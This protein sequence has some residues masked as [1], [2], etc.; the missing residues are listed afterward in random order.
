MY[1]CLVGSD[2][3]EEKKTRFFSRIPPSP[4]PHLRPL[5]AWIP[6]LGCV[7]EMK[8]NLHLRKKHIISPSSGSTLQKFCIK[9]KLLPGQTAL[10]VCRAGCSFLSIFAFFLSMTSSPPLS[11]MMHF[12]HKSISLSLLLSPD[13]REEE[14]SEHR[15]QSHF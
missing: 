12:A 11:A 3:K 1:G 15:H 7:S 2:S 10:V 4:P 13:E 14:N 6:Y 8:A 5:Q 9:K